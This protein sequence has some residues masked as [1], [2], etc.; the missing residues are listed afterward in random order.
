MTGHD[1][2]SKQFRQ[3]FR[4]LTVTDPG[5]FLKEIERAREKD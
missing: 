5:D 4:F 2:Q 3:R 1:A